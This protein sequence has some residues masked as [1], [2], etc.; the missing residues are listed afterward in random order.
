MILYH[1]SSGIAANTVDEEMYTEF[2][3]E[4]VAW[5]SEH[6]RSD[7]Q[8]RVEVADPSER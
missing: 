7:N 3:V 5:M 1:V 8:V 6:L 4:A 2:W